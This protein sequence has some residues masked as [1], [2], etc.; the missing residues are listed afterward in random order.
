MASEEDEY[1]TDTGSARKKPLDTQSRCSLRTELLKELPGLLV[2]GSSDSELFIQSI[3]ETTGL[4]KQKVNQVDS[5]VL[6]HRILTLISSAKVW[7]W[8]RRREREA[9]KGQLS[10]AIA[11]PFFNIQE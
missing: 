10:L 5:I 7:L 6:V 9:Q 2:A 3:A 4:N 8:R 11:Q 1:S